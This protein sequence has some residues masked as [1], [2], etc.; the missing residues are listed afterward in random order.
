M[1]ETVSTPTPPPT[2]DCAA[3]QQPLG[4][5]HYRFGERRVCLN[6][7]GQL[8]AMQERNRFAGGPVMVALVVGVITALVCGAVWAG[9]AVAAHSEWGIIAVGIG[10]VVGTV[11]V[12]AA[13]N[14]RGR[15]L[16]IVAITCS[17]LGILLGKGLSFVFALMSAEGFQTLD[18]A[19]K[20]RLLREFFFKGV[21]RFELFDILW[22]FLAIRAAWQLTKAPPAQ[23]HGPYPTNVPPPPAGMQFETVEPM[24]PPQA[25]P[26]QVPQ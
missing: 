22:F 2:A 7:A 6:C 5:Q 16:Q 21:I 9:I 23:L 13:G 10:F 15:P 24:S 18:S 4:D 17:I 11:V 8:H 14:R 3:C 25:P 20:A 12:K 1:S 26:P 19:T